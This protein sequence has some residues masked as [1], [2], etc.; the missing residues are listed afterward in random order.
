VVRKR[1]HKKMKKTM[2]IVTA[3]TFTATLALALVASGDDAYAKSRAGGG[4]K[5]NP[6]GDVVITITLDPGAS[7]TIVDLGVT[8]E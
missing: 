6:N 7:E 3:L 5:H 1:V 4:S 2:R 8:W